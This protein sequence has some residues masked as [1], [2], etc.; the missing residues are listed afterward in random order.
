MRWWGKTVDSALWTRRLSDLELII[1]LSC[2][3]GGG[4]E[5]YC[6]FGPS[7]PLPIAEGCLWP[8]HDRPM[9]T[10]GNPLALQHDRRVRSRRAPFL[11][12]RLHGVV[13]VAV[14]AVAAGPELTA[15][16]TPSS[17]SAPAVGI[18]VDAISASRATEQEPGTV[19]QSP[20][21]LEILLERVLALEARDDSV[22]ARIADLQAEL[23]RLREE[24]ARERR[25]RADELEELHQSLILLLDSASTS[26]V[27]AILAR[28]QAGIGAVRAEGEA[29][30]RVLGNRVEGVERE[31]SALGTRVEDWVAV[32]ADSLREA[33]G[34]IVQEQGERQ[35]GD[36]HNAILA[37][38]VAGLLLLGVGLVG[39]YGRRRVATLDGRIRRIEPDVAER[40]E[41]AREEI[42]AG[43]RQESGELLSQQ[44]SSLEQI[45][46]ML[47]SIQT[48]AE[49]RAPDS[50][51]ADHDLPLGVCNEL[52]RIE[53]NLLA[54]DSTVRGHKQ[55]TACVRRVKENLK[56]HDYEITELLGKP[57]HRGMDVE[58]DF[59][60]TDELGV[61]ERIITRINRPEVRY[62]GIS[63]QGASVTIS[64][65]L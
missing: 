27:N 7:F 38:I 23:T 18:V 1:G 50:V 59:V 52:N 19:D 8:Y 48:L 60:A 3:D 42:A 17:G 15:A 14:A 53:K 54:M 22:T 9:T 16:S 44:L 43:V 10:L 45:T 2:N 51:E 6:A 5:A 32:V 58:A 12:H 65:G 33:E 55:L 40:I 36:R 35:T 64:Q 24:S 11:C 13:I 4:E 39:W 46:A 30:R 47:G 25:L 61:D 20:D 21:T 62:G 56:V 49:A 63:I 29:G 37:G 57:Y 31:L 28:L 34:R 26:A 41:K